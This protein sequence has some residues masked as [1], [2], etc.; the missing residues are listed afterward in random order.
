MEKE[1]QRGK[2]IDSDLPRL[3]F[4]GTPG[5][6]VPSLEKLVTAHAPVILVVTQPDQPSGRGRKL[7]APPVKAV[8]EEFGISVYQPE[9]VKEPEAIEYISSYGAEC[10]VVVAYG[11]ILPQTLLNSFAL[12]TLNVH[13]SLLPAYRGA[14]PI[15]RCLLAGDTRTGISIMLLDEGMD[16]GPVLLQRAL[17]IEEEDNFGTLHDK[18][19]SLGA[20]LLLETLREWRAGH[21]VPIPQV[22]A[23]STYAPP[24]LKIER[25]VD[26]SL[27]A[28]EIVNVI[29]AFD[30]QPGAYGVFEG[31][32]LRFFRAQLLALKGYGKGGEIVGGS[33]KGLVVLGGDGR[34]LV[35][36]ELQ[37][38]GRR[39]VEAADFLRGH[40]M[41]AGSLLQ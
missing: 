34:G 7:R 35:I 18:M 26:W 12:G 21:I 31:Q 36:R 38:E 2:S 23:R 37:L 13:A 17:D 16:T 39:R 24:I 4:F 25:H 19:A 5:F 27:S 32:R 15:Q 33:E 41:P 29:R 20:D 8:A 9:R 10:A 22:D 1:A 14:A 11:K 6:S 28:R 30:P 3:V 40:A